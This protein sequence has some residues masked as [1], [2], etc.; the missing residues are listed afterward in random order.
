MKKRIIAILLL[1]PYLFISG[2]FVFA[3][4]GESP[5]STVVVTPTIPVRA[6]T[7][8]S[9]AIQTITADELGKL[10]VTTAQDVLNNKPNTPSG[11]PV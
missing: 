5:I 4:G 7:S 8:N 6:D 1:T 3:E 10:P 2:N 11:T 9:H